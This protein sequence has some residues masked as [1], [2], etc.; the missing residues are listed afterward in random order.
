MGTVINALKYTP[1]TL[2]QTDALF[3][4]R[5]NR[6][7]IALL[8]RIAAEVELAH[9]PTQP[10]N[11]LGHVFIPADF[12]P[13][14]DGIGFDLAEIGKGVFLAA[15]R[16]ALYIT[17]TMREG[18]PVEYPNIYKAG[19]HTAAYQFQIRLAEHSYASRIHRFLAASNLTGA[20]IR[21]DGEE[22][23]LTDIAA[24]YPPVPPWQT[25]YAST[26]GE[27]TTQDDFA[28]LDE[29]ETWW[30]IWQVPYLVQQGIKLKSATEGELI[31]PSFN[32]RILMDA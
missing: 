10:D 5:Q 3:A 9:F 25:R 14:G 27:L 20:T 22:G 19:R 4:L 29:N 12:I 21:K 7:E 17:A 8:R 2:T 13:F 30:H 11:W 23:R 24:G 31:T 6:D 16:V 15:D 1:G 28:V 18:K 26:F 32:V